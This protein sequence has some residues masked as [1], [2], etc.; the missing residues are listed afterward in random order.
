MRAI[1][2][3]VALFA[4]A[5]ISN[6]LGQQQADGYAG[7]LFNITGG[8]GGMTTIVTTATAFSTAVGST[9]PMVILFSNTL[10]LAGNVRVQNNKTIMGLGTAAI[11]SNGCL[12]MDSSTNIIVRNVF[13]TNVGSLGDGDAMT[14]KD[15][16]QRI[17]VDHCTFVD[18]GDEGYSMTHGSDFITTS[19]CKFYYTFNSGHN[20]V[21]LIG[22]SDSASA[23]AEDTGKLHVTFHHNWWGR[24]C[25]ERMPRVR[26]GKVHTYNNYFN[27]ST[28]SSVI[29]NYCVR[30][31]R[32]SEVLI[33]NN[34]FERVKNPWE[35]FVTVGITG[36]V[37]AAG[38][39][40]INTTTSTG[41]GIFIPPGTDTVFTVP[42]PYTMDPTNVVAGIVTNYAGAGVLPAPFFNANTT[43]GAAPLTVTFTNTSYGVIT[44]CFWDFGAAGTTNTMS[45]IVTRTF[46][47]AGTYSISL[48]VRGPVGSN[49]LTKSAYI[50]ATSGVT[51][52][53]ARF[54]A[55]PTNGVEPLVVTFSDTS[56]GT[57]PLSLFWD[58]GDSTTTNTAGGASFPHSYSAGVYTVT[59]TAS[60]SAGTST[61]VSNNLI[62]VIT[63]LQAWQLQYFGCTNC[64]QADA[65]ADP[66]GDGMSN[67]NEFLTGTAPTNALSALRIISATA[68]GN[69]VAITWRTAGGRTNVVQA[70]AG[71]V[72]GD[73]TNDF[74][75][76]TGLF[77]I[78]G[79]GDATTNH[80]DTNGATNSPARYYRIRLA[81]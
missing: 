20:F 50:V 69:D 54:T 62:T 11:L 57:P 65:D 55:S 80:V 37:Y 18:G 8:T 24:L 14:V 51:P 26:F 32:D 75:D 76:L 47:S 43:S 56:T 60:N 3:A 6:A 25:V 78:S 74:T 46:S 2:C 23:A 12:Q 10:N 5:G 41:S 42:Y 13:A 39:A 70:T 63:A 19:W 4:T 64:P 40:L 79:S 29:N 59:L 36:K 81:P 35:V 38:N 49:T 16:S 71:G 28:N 72:D 73:Y 67:S 33:E 61:L 48:T 7:H 22:H 52:P 53:T 45:N 31:A 34:V 44:N 15:F 68:S 77:V 30:A 21:N 17:W 9:S 66:D 1:T 27:A 58:L